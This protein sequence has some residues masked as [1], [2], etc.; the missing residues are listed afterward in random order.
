M[1][2]THLWRLGVLAYLPA[3]DLISTRC[4]EVDEV[5]GPETSCDD[6]VQRRGSTLL[7]APLITVTLWLLKDLLLFEQGVIFRVRAG[8]TVMK[9]SDKQGGGSAIGGASRDC[10]RGFQMQARLA[11]STRAAAAGDVRSTTCTCRLSF[12]P[13]TTTNSRD[14][15]SAH[16]ILIG[17]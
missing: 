10:S 6:L 5:D 17:S 11:S 4:E 15:P 7:L 14:H 13:L 8:E 9:D 1:S 2:T 12:H 3:L 16:L